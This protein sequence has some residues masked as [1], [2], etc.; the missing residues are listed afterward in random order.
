VRKL[1][2]FLVILAVIFVAGDYAARA[3][4]EKKAADQL[5][6]RLGLSSAPSV[7]F[8]GWPFLVHAFSGAFPGVHVSADRLDAKG[9]TFSDLRLDLEDVTFSV[10][11]ILNGRARAVRARGGTGTISI[12]ESS[13]NQVLGRAGAPFDVNLGAG[14]ATADIPGVGSQSVNVSVESGSLSLGAS[15]LPSPFSIALPQV[16]DSL[17]YESGRVTDSAVVLQVKLGPTSLQRPAG[18]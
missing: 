18:L 3:F 4:A 15:G 1:L 11:D 6:T 13:L 12:S 7:G 8:S 16:L 14:K 17:T 5:Q 2:V 9:I 10:R